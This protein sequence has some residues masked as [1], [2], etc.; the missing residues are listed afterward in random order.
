MYFWLKSYWRYRQFAWL[1]FCELCVCTSIIFAFYNLGYCVPS[2]IWITCVYIKQSF[3][4]EFQL[5]NETDY[6]ILN[7]RHSGWSDTLFQFSNVIQFWIFPTLCARNQNGFS[8]SLFL[9]WTRHR[10]YFLYGFCFC[11]RFCF[12]FHSL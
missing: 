7:A 11:F 1:Q 9:S 8:W 2:S 3:E 10:L 5:L 4:L 12:C 6:F